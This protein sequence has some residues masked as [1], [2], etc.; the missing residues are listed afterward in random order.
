MLKQLKAFIPQIIWLTICGAV[1]AFADIII[2]LKIR[3][4]IDQSRSGDFSQFNNGIWMMSLLS[5]VFAIGL[6]TF[7]YF[8]A[9][10]I[11]LSLT[12]MKQQYVRRVFK[13]IST[14]FNGKT[15]QL[16]CLHSQMTTIKSK[17]IS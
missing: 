11:R 5:V 10:F 9:L 8:K 7:H 15:I 16:I 13:K 14:S 2:A 3:D 4:I 6:L 1:S 17:P 12:K